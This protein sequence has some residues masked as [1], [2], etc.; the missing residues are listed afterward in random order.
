MDNKRTVY[1]SS[2]KGYLHTCLSIIAISISISI[3]EHHL[4]YL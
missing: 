3:Y 4:S 1:V 2:I